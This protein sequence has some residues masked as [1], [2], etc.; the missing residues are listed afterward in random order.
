[1]EEKKKIEVSAS[2]NVGLEQV[3]DAW[4]NPADI[5]KW[6]AADPSWHCPKSENDLRTGG[7]F[8]NRM[9]AKDGSFG[10]DFMGTYTEVSPKSTISYV[11]GDGRE[12]STTFAESEGQTQ[13]TTVFDAETVNDPEMQR[14]GWQSILN[15]FIT[16]VESK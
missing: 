2:T 7:S 3:W 15:N 5:V 11:L 8:N 16:Y 13:I 4:N 10:F 9:E 14:A 6:N 1:M 12:V